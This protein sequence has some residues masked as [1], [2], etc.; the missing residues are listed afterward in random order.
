[1]VE[2]ALARLKGDTLGAGVEN[3]SFHNFVTGKYKR[4]WLWWCTQIRC[5]C[6]LALFKS[7][8]VKIPC[9]VVKLLGIHHHP[10]MTRTSSGRCVRGRGGGAMFIVFWLNYQVCLQSTDYFA[11][12]PFL[13]IYVS[14]MPQKHLNLSIPH[15]PPPE[16][17]PSLSFSLRVA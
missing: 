11:P 16:T 1:M 3:A 6:I 10:I 17:I 5:I 8:H 4:V 7:L 13:T 15:P 14:N 12:H 2:K 9:Y